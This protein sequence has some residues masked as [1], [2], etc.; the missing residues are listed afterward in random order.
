MNVP[1]H[2]SEKLFRVYEPYIASILVEYPNA[3]TFTP[4]T[5]ATTTFT[6]RL[7]DAINSVLEFEWSTT[8]NVQKLREIRRSICILNSGTTV[9]C[10]RKESKTIDAQS[11]VDENTQ[12]KQFALVLTNPTPEDVKACCMLLSSR[13]ITRPIKLTA[14]SCLYGDVASHYDVAIETL[15]NGD[16]VL[17]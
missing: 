1:P 3:V 11:A 6:A 15:S 9:I 10:S 4:R 13:A 2:K 17:I 16:I 7:R 8:I 14:V 12:S 5:V